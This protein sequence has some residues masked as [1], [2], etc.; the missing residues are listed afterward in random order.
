MAA[1][2]TPKPVLLAVAPEA[3]VGENRCQQIRLCPAS[4]YLIC[5]AYLDGSLN[6]WEIAGKPCCKRDDF[7]RCLDCFIY[8][9]AMGQEERG[10]QSRLED[11]AVGKPQ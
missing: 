7:A 9:R 2:P 8:L 10:G 4:Q 6:C 1:E 3:Q 5:S 11:S